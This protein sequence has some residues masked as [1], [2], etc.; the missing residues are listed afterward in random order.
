MLEAT[1]KV[2]KVPLSYVSKVFFNRKSEGREGMVELSVYCGESCECMSFQI[3]ASPSSRD[4]TAIA[5]L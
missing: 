4:Y 1:F 5:K 3:Q 2:I